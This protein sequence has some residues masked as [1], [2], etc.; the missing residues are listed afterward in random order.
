MAGCVFARRRIPH[1]KTRQRREMAHR[2][3]LGENPRMVPKMMSQLQLVRDRYDQA[4]LCAG[5]QSARGRVN[6]NGGGAHV[7]VRKSSI[8]RNDTV[9]ALSW[10]ERA[11]SAA[12]WDEAAHAARERGRC[13]QGMGSARVDQ[14]QAS[15][16]VCGD[17]AGA[18]AC[19]GG[20]PGKFTEH[21]AQEGPRQLGLIPGRLRSRRGSPKGLRLSV[22]MPRGSM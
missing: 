4:D 9:R 10:Y 19:A 7:G 15:A 6:P 11:R 18:S 16:L 5:R 21:R 1:W 12:G 14:A 22:T 13:A 8:G 17:H 20:T 2:E 3:A